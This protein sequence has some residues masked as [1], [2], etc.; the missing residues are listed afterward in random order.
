MHHSY[1]MRQEKVAKGESRGNSM[2]KLH[3]ALI[4]PMTGP[5]GLF[6]QTCAT[7]LTLWA[8]HAAH[9]PSPWTD[10]EL[11][12]WDSGSNTGAAVRTALEKQPDV[13]FGPYGSA[14]M[15]SAARACE[16]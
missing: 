5:L 12:V 11:D 9:L 8:K 1:A 10:I 7:A 14:P 4:T 15:L 13:L 16:R 6:G 2:A 3:A